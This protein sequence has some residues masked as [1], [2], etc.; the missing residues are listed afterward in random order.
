MEA[1]KIFVLVL[2]VFAVGTLVFLELKSR[3]SKR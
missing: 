3:R 1:G 2:T